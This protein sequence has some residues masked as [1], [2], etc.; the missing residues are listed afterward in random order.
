MSFRLF[1]LIFCGKEALAA[2]QRAS[3]PLATFNQICFWLTIELDLF[4]FDENQQSDGEV[5]FQLRLPLGEERSDLYVK[6]PAWQQ[7]AR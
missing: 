5:S 3:V 7:P 4:K 6:Q 2:V 1:R